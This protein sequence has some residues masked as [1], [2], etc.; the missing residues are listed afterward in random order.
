[1][2]DKIP[3]QWFMESSHNFS[4][5]PTIMYRSKSSNSTL[6]Q[7]LL[8]LLIIGVLRCNS[9]L[10]TKT[11]LRKLT[12]DRRHL[13]VTQNDYEELLD[14]ESSRSDK[15]IES[16]RSLLQRQE[17]DIEMTK[18]LLAT[19]EDP[20]QGGNH[21]TPTLGF[22][23]GFVSRS[24]G[25]GFLEIR[26]DIPGYDGPPANVWTLGWGQFW[27][28]W[29]AI[30][31]EYK[32]EEDVELTQQQQGLRTKLSELTLDSNEIWKR[33]ENTGIVA[34]LIIKAPY[35]VLCWFLDTLFEN[36]YPF[37]RFFL[38]ETVARVPYFS[39]ISMIH[40]YETLGMCINACGRET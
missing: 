33:E 40:L 31:G 16:L 28:N 20:S 6:Q 23:Y 27:R 9:L 26:G 8:L 19:I 25:P 22:N 10:Q 5:M 7:Q 18:K 39:Y 35:V 21:I 3:F 30:K 4:F 2:Y 12:L 29:D 34:P 14:A 15:A 1:M 37:A 11:T 32:D 13:H 24:E 36:R 38:L 17:A